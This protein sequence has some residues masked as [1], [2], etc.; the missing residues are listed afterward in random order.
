MKEINQHFQTPNSVF[1]AKALK[2]VEFLT[3]WLGARLLR[4]LLLTS[5]S[6]FIS[7]VGSLYPE[8]ESRRH[9][10]R[11]KKTPANPCWGRFVDIIL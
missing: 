7:T 5:Q 10:E 3:S 11:G 6:H 2:L 4:I 8:N 9:T 1:V